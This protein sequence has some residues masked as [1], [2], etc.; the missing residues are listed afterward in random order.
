MSNKDVFSHTVSYC[1]YHLSTNCERAHLQCS[2][3]QEEGRFNVTQSVVVRAGLERG[4]LQAAQGAR[5][6][7][8]QQSQQFG[9]V[10]GQLLQ[11]PH[12]EGLQRATVAHQRQQRLQ[13]LPV[14]IAVSCSSRQARGQCLLFQ[15]VLLGNLHCAVTRLQNDALQLAVLAY[16][17]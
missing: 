2:E 16:F 15:E 8:C 4:K 13:H 1:T 11:A 6:V 5:L 7:Q 3:G 10:Q 9:G 17:L 14:D 12:T